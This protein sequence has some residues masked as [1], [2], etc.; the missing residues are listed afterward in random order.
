MGLE[1][2]LGP[3][4]RDGCLLEFS[5][6]SFPEE[7]L[8]IPT[9]PPPNKFDP[10]SA[11]QTS[12]PLPGFSIKNLPPVVSVRERLYRSSRAGRLWWKWPLYEEN[13]KLAPEKIKQMVARRIRIFVQFP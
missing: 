8:E 9:Y 2:S 6:D 1:S 13:W 12:P 7:D 5:H 3:M 10:S 11:I 4:I